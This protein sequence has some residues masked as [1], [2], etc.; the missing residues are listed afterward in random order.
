MCVLIGVL[1]QNQA[2]LENAIAP[3]PFITFLPFGSASVYEEMRLCER[4]YRDRIRIGPYAQLNVQ[5]AIRK[6]TLK[7]FL[8][9]AL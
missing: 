3:S 1:L 4:K 5:V 2:F 9:L 7:Y 8:L 6:N